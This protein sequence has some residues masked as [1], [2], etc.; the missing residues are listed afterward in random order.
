MHKAVGQAWMGLSEIRST[1]L[2]L[3]NMGGFH[4]GGH[5]INHFQH[6]ISQ[7]LQPWM[8]SCTGISL[9]STCAKEIQSCGTYSVLETRL[10]YM[11]FTLQETRICQKE[12]EETQQTS[13][14][15]QVLHSSWSPIL[16]VHFFKSQDKSPLNG[17]M[18]FGFNILCWVINSS[19]PQ[20]PNVCP[21]FPWRAR[22]VTI[23]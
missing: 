14:L 20:L 8:D 5:E 16:K 15:K 11:G 21:S 17:F 10:M 18:S 6:A 4:V 19:L 7:L 3:E 1:K 2:A 13:S 12:K 23:S 22:R 9:V